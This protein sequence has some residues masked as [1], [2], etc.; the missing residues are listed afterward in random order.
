MNITNFE[1]NLSLNE[2]IYGLIKQDVFHK[3]QLKDL[4][5][6]PEHFLIKP[7]EYLKLNDE[8]KAKANKK[9]EAARKP[10]PAYVFLKKVQIFNLEYIKYMTKLNTFYVYNTQ[11]GYYKE[12]TVKE[13]HVILQHL[14]K[15]TPLGQFMNLHNYTQTIVDELKASVSLCLELP[16]NERDYLCMKNGVLNLKNKRFIKHTHTLFFTQSVPYVYKE[17]ATCPLFLQFLQDF[18]NGYE[19]RIAFLRA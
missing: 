14:L 16:E 7:E 4:T 3:L 1:K 12:I 5:Y 13:I 6:I 8:E 18:T 10:L 11:K 2:E 15:K 17:E 19:D 9:M